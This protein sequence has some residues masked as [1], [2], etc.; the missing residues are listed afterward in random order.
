MNENND[1]LG[2]GETVY[3]TE[4]AENTTEGEGV[5]DDK[6]VYKNKEWLYHQYHVLGK[7]AREISKV[8]DCSHSTIRRYMDKYGIELREFSKANSMG[9]GG[10]EMLW[11]GDWI[12]K[13]YVDK[14]RSI[15]D[16]AVE[17]RVEPDTVARSLRRHGIGVRSNSE[18][19]K[20]Q[21]ERENSGRKYRDRDWLEFQYWDRLRSTCDISDE[22]GCSTNT[23]GRWLDKHNIPKRSQSEA[24]KLRHNGATT[25]LKSD[26][27]E[28]EFVAKDED[29]SVILD[30]SWTY[31]H[32]RP[33]AE[34]R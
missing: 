12:K 28:R 6:P 29:G 13:Q 24:A 21:A 10:D 17:R 15:V 34:E 20:I 26:G 14:K 22:L 5:E 3:A 11:D 2:E 33:A 16:L 19:A 1:P 30:Q 32:E 4:P 31:F 8:A 9:H 25:N 23:V 18:S 7:S 27:D